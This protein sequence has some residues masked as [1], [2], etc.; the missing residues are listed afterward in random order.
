LIPSKSKRILWWGRGDNSYSRNKIMLTLLGDLG[1]QVNYFRPRISKLGKIEAL[2]KSIEIPNY[3]WVPC[4]RHNDVLS[5]SYFARKWKIPLIFDP[6]IS[7]YQKDVFERGK[8]QEN[9]KKAKERKRWESEI[10]SKPDMIICDTQAHADYFKK[11]FGVRQ[12]R[13]GVVYI[14]AEENCYINDERRPVS[15][16]YN[17]LF[18]GSF[19]ELQGAHVIVQAAKSAK[20]LP[21]TW[22]LVG[23]G[24]C[25][26]DVKQIADGMGNLSFKPWMSYKNLQSEIAKAD[27]L[28]GVFGDTMKANMVIPNKVFQ[29][30]IAG[31]PLITQQADAYIGNIAKNKTI[32]WVNGN[33]PESIRRKLF[34]WLE[35]PEKLY[36]RGIQTKMLYDKYFS[37]SK[38]FTMLENIFCAIS[39]GR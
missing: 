38:L 6:L 34:E 3:I 1:F 16:P 18:Y 21:V 11:N 17:I 14:G 28:L 4:F 26:K 37:K 12:D 35:E 33:D 36:D 29:T 13:L 10:F 39:T 24:P 15:E 19:L 32:G 2:T 30:M 5:A 9:N 8:W 20:E 7:A 22:T 31:K 25:L 27:I 23:E